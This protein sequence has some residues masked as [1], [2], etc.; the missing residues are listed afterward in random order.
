LEER[1]GES[2]FTKDTLEL[3]YKFWESP[4]ERVERLKRI[5]IDLKKKNALGG[6]E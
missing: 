4:E 1:A 2:I 5:W 6:I 3:E